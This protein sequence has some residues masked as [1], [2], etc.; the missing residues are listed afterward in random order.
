VS[1]RGKSP[2]CR[3]RVQQ[4][5]DDLNRHDLNDFDTR[6]GLFVPASVRWAVLPDMAGTREADAI[7][8][9]DTGTVIEPVTIE[10]TE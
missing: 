8:R 7:R 2:F 5:R 6:S 1:Y 4:D 3:T 9:Y 10:T